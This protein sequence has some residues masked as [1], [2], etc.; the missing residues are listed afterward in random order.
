M[1]F[2]IHALPAEPFARLLALPD[3]ALRTRGIR[4]ARH[5][6]AL[7]ALAFKWIRILFR[8]WK[9]RVPYDDS[10]YLMALQ[11]KQSPL[12]KFVADNPS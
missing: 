10:R 2:Q 5:Q 9:D 11:K 4:R 7:R 6:A 12:L 8:C 3:D 1:S